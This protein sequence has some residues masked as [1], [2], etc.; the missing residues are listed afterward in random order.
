MGMNAAIQ[1]LFEQL[2]PPDYEG[3]A[4]FLMARWHKHLER[5]ENIT[6]FQPHKTAADDLGAG[7]YEVVTDIPEGEGLYDTALVAITKNMLES[8]YLLARAITA[9]RPGGRL[10]AAGENF[11]GGRRLP[12]L[13]Q[14]F[15]LRFS[16]SVSRYKSRAV[17]VEVEDYDAQAV[18]AALAGGEAQQVLDG[19]YISRPG[20]FGW[21]KVDKGSALLACALPDYLSGRGADFGCG[22]GYLS[23]EALQGH[24]DI[25][26]LI[27]IDVDARA[28]ACCEKNLKGNDKT[29]TLWADLTDPSQ[30]P[31]N[32]DFILMNPPFHDGKQTDISLGTAMIENAAKALSPGG[33]LW[34]VANR[35]LPYEQPLQT[36]F[37]NVEKVREEN[38][39]KVFRANN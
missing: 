38:G 9:L 17:S 28:V 15:G 12:K 11:A 26:E 35:H 33:V 18:Q 29:K 37:K 21:N 2:A 4:L 10:I 1:I 34:M 6:L 19:A 23:R 16:N 22:Y 32:L 13:L 36:L 30:A 39:F 8:R 3:R 25:S 20:I 7:G 24:P 5:F 31:Q 14:E 27:A